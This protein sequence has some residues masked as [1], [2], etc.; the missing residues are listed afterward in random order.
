V[1]LWPPLCVSEAE[2][3]WGRGPALPLTPRERA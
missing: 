3:R 1:A 2:V